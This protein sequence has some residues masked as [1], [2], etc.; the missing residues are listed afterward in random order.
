MAEKKISMIYILVLFIC[1]YP[2][3]L[4]RRAAGFYQKR[5]DA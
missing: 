4:K 5:D 3:D 2:L 1:D